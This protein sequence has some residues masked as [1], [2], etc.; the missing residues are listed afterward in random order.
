MSTLNFL[1]QTIKNHEVSFRNTLSQSTQ[2]NDTIPSCKRSFLDFAESIFALLSLSMLLTLLEAKQED[3]KEKTRARIN[4]FFED[5]HYYSTRQWLHRLF[6]VP[7]EL[8]NTIWL[9]Y[10]VLAQTFGAYSNCRCITSMY[11]L[12]GGYVDLAQANT[13]DNPYVQ[14]YWSAGTALSCA[15]LGLG[16]IYI[17]TEWCL[18]A[19]IS[20]EEVKN[21]RRGL[22]K[23]RYFRKFMYWP[24]RTSRKV[25]VFI[26]NLVATLCGISKKNRQKTLFWSKD[27]TFEY[28]TDHFLSPRVQ[29]QASTKVCHLS[30]LATG[31]L[32]ILAATR[33]GSLCGQPPYINS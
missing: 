6:F 21:A 8:F 2:T 31:G 19:H 10:I 1:I 26:N 22:R 12:H 28:A 33:V 3:K 5:T 4:K 11:G 13:T 30:L 24:R 23:T 25:I 7:V 15:I 29:R 16:L 14:Y 9:V 27:V 17:V 18:Q 20:T 32:P